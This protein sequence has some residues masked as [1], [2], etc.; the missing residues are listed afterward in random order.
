VILDEAPGET[1]LVRL[2]AGLAGGAEVVLPDTDWSGP[3]RAR[4]FARLPDAGAGPGV[5]LYTSGTTAEP[6]PFFR[7]TAELATMVERIRETVPADLAA[8]RPAGRCLAPLD[9]GFGL[10]NGLF[11]VHALGGTV[12]SSDAPA[13]LLFGWPVHF[14]ALLDEGIGRRTELRWCVSAAYGL[15]RETAAAFRARTGCPLRQLYGT[16]ELGP[17]CV[18]TDEDPE[19]PCVG[20][21]L[22]GVEIEVD[23]DGALTAR[24][25]GDRHATGDLGRLDDLGRVYVLGRAGPFRD[26]RKDLAHR[27]NP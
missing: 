10:M 6:R 13:Q 20:R 9:H 18:D 1:W 2:L 24:V 4:A 27:W 15:D 14:R 7:S 12:V 19:P 16:T 26:E 21:P 22:R 17:L 8:A 5:W 3:E 23:D 25:G 11:L